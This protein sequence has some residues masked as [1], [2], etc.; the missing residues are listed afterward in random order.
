MIFKKFLYTLLI[1]TLFSVSFLYTGVS[2]SLAQTLDPN[3]PAGAPDPA[4]LAQSGITTVRVVLKDDGV[5]PQY[6]AA[7]QANGIQ[8]IGIVNW[9]YGTQGAYPSNQNSPEYAQY[10]ANTLIPQV[11]ATYG[12]LYAY[13]VWNEPDDIAM[14]DTVKFMDAA[15]YGQLLNQAYGAIKDLNASQIVFSAGLVSGN[16]AYLQGI[17]DGGGLADVYALHP[18]DPNPDDPAAIDRVAAL[19][20]MMTSITG[21]PVFITEFGWPTSDQEAQAKWLLQVMNLQNDPALSSYLLGVMWYA[22]SDGQNPGFGLLDANMQPK[23]AYFAYLEILKGTPLTNADLLALLA[24]KAVKCLDPNNGTFMGFAFNETQ[25]ARYE[26]CKDPNGTITGYAIRLPS[27]ILGTRPKLCDIQKQYVQKCAGRIDL[28]KRNY[29]GDV[30]GHNG[31]KPF[32]IE[33]SLGQEILFGDPNQEGAELDRKLAKVLRSNLVISAEYKHVD[34]E[35]ISKRYSGSIEPS[36]PHYIENRVTLNKA[37][38]PNLI[39]N[40]LDRFEGS[41]GVSQQPFCQTKNGESYTNCL[42]RVYGATPS[43]RDSNGQTLGL[44][45]D[46]QTL[47]FTGCIQRLGCNPKIE[48]CLKAD[49]LYNPSDPKVLTPYCNDDTNVKYKDPANCIS[50]G[51]VINFAGKIVYEEPSALHSTAYTYDEYLRNTLVKTGTKNKPGFKE[52]Y[53][54]T[55]DDLLDP[56]KKNLVFGQDAKPQRLNQAGIKASNASLS[57]PTKANAVDG[58]LSAIEPNTSIPNATCDGRISTQIEDHGNYFSL[59]AWD[60]REKDGGGQCEPMADWDLQV[61]YFLNGKPLGGCT[62]TSITGSTM[63]PPVGDPSRPQGLVLSDLGVEG[64]PSCGV[65]VTPQSL[66]PGEKVEAMVQVLHSNASDQNGCFKTAA[67][68]SGAPK[69]V[70]AGQ[71]LVDCRVCPSW[72]PKSVCAQIIGTSIID[73]DECVDGNCKAQINLEGGAAGSKVPV[74]ENDGF[75]FTQWAYENLFSWFG[76]ATGSS[77][78]NCVAITESRQAIGADGKPIPNG[79]GGFVLE[80]YKVGVKCRFNARHYNLYV[81]PTVPI[82]G[83]F[84]QRATN[85]EV[86]NVISSMEGW[87]SKYFEPEPNKSTVKLKLNIPAG[88]FQAFSSTDA[89]VLADKK[90]PVNTWLGGL[91]DYSDPTVPKDYLYVGCKT[92]ADCTRDMHV[93]FKYFV[94]PQASG[95]CLTEKFLT[96][97]QNKNNQIPKS[98]ADSHLCDTFDFIPDGNGNSR[99]ALDPNELAKTKTASEAVQYELT[100][101]FVLKQDDIQKDLA[102]K[103]DSIE[104][105]KQDLIYAKAPI[106]KDRTATEKEQELAL[107]AQSLTE[108]QKDQF[109]KEFLSDMEIIV[110]KNFPFMSPVDPTYIP[111]QM[112]FDLDKLK[113]KYEQKVHQMA[114]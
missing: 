46:F 71:S 106:I 109:K 19:I 29:R 2:Q 42:K 50:L 18:Y 86:N 87:T 112:Q 81:Y 69:K 83:D 37:N 91:L 9:E 79:S 67:C 39:F 43:N 5:T 28:E 15:A 100:R 74:Q 14:S 110:I 32:N 48:K 13:Q 93:E 27:D 75:S 55:G 51:Q 21:K 11:Y 38:T 65:P 8:V 60:T 59:N 52:L 45:S 25:C 72:A 76:A 108:K 113:I 80:N 36:S 92:A 101:T 95:Y 22:Y 68:Y 31:E 85:M 73:R 41:K 3:N 6:V 88:G 20:Q 33:A 7:L 16:A 61:D 89:E 57:N 70:G 94:Q 34:Y 54:D 104:S 98:L 96:L 12:N 40:Y 44:D 47:R 24:G 97:N 23:L 99:M 84:G 77:G 64:I 102:N 66:K 90:Q 35:Q 114:S 63:I 56:N 17:I 62:L 58:Q 4:L 1:T 10:F 103:V 82:P 49:V 78:G 111:P 107:L 105:A 30:V 53:T 26:A